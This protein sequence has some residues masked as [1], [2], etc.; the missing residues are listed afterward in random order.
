MSLTRDAY[1]LL[2]L[3]GKAS[4]ICEDK[5]IVT[6]DL[7]SPMDTRTRDRLNSFQR[8]NLMFDITVLKECM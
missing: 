3:A 2:G 8:W 4:K 5:Y 1:Q 7:L 6:I